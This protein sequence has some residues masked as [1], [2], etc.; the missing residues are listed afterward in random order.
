M[1]IKLLHFLIIF[2]CLVKLHAQ[3]RALTLNQFVFEDT[4]GK[5]YN[6]DL[7]RGKVIYVDCW[8]PSCPPCRTEMP[9]SKLLQQRL[10]TMQIDTN[11]VFVTICFKQTIDDWKEALSELPMPTALHLYSPASTYEIALS[12]GNYPTYRI[13]NKNGKLDIENAPKPSEFLKIDFILFAMEK[14]ESIASATKIFDAEKNIEKNKVKHYLLKAF[15]AKELS[16]DIKFM[17]DFMQLQ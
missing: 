12:G 5:K 2:G 14:G 4:S 3:P 6:L 17:K 9:Y 15:Y 8:F 10:Q 1:K 13:F 11:I 16:H 7:L